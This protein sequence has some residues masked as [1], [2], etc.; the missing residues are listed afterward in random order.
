MKKLILVLSS[1]LILAASCNTTKTQKGAAIGA[2]AGAVIGGLIGKKS[3]NTAVGV[4][5][6]ATLGGAAG[7]VIGNQMDKQAAKMQKDLGKD[8]KV[9]RVG[10]GIKLTFDSQIL[11]DYGKADLRE[12][13]K[14]AIIKLTES[15]KEY[16]NTNILIVGHTDN[17]GADDYN[18]RLS[19]ERAAS[20]SNYLSSLNISS[21][22]LRTEGRGEMEP[23]ATNDT[24]AGRQLNRRVELAITANEKMKEEAG[25]TSTTSKS[26]K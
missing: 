22:R 2:G 4:V 14:S 8:A 15:L 23:V 20:V 17:K 25:A 13:N 11:F 3:K 9:E 6:G 12:T 19:Q 24:D 10:E 7:A 1:I 18:M 21:S 16:P 26:G 5:L